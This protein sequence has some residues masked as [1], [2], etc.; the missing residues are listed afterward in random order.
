MARMVVIFRTP[1]DAASFDMHYF[2]VHVPLAKALPG[3]RKYVV[4]RAPVV[5]LNGAAPCHLV[6]TLY[7]DTLAAIKA[8]FASEQGQACAVDRRRL[9]ADA[10]VQTFLFDDTE[11]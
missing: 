7:F 8:A 11:V 5:S 6:A 10:D 1:Q 2:G 9:A 4:S 3:L